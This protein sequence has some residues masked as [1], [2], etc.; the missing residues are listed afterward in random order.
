M[1]ELTIFTYVCNI[2]D[3]PKT[4]ITNAS[5]SQDQ[6][7]IEVKKIP[8]S[9]NIDPFPLIE[10]L[11]SVTDGI[12]VTCCQTAQC[13]SI[14]EDNTIKY[15][16]FFVKKLLEKIGIKPVR[17]DYKEILSSETENFPQIVNNYASLITEVGPMTQNDKK[18]IQDEIEIL[19][20]ICTDSYFNWLLKKSY[21]LVQ[22]SNV[23]NEKI[24]EER[25]LRSM[26]EL[27]EAEIINKR[28]IDLIRDN[29]L[30]PKDIAQKLSLSPET[31]MKQLLSLKT[32]QK[33]QL[34][35]IDQNPSFILKVH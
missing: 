18:L 24:S 9:N 15:K 11:S 6:P 26:D 8:C 3:Y 33:I 32:R 31:A 21:Q 5:E 29:P 30:T 12:L 14:S 23:Y 19:K 2:C 25:L 1:S 10:A 13:Q 20:E 34:K 27:I 17:I 35:M 7:K 4:T 16:V 28:I 22:F